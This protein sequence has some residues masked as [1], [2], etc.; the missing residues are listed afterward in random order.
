[1]RRRRLVLFA[2]LVGAL[3]AITGHMYDVLDSAAE[4][5]AR[6]EIDGDDHLD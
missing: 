3:V 5:L 6:T 2:V 4:L 1:M